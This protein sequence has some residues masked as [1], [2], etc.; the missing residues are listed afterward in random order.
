[1]DLNQG[2]PSSHH[3]CLEKDQ[4]SSAQSQYNGAPMSSFPAYNSS[5]DADLY[6]IPSYASSNANQFYPILGQ[7]SSGSAGLSTQT[8]ATIS[9]DHNQTL[10]PYGAQAMGQFTQNLPAIDVDL[11][12][13]EPS[14]M[15]FEDFS[16]NF[17]SNEG[18]SSIAGSPYNPSSPHALSQSINPAELSRQPS[19]NSSASPHPPSVRY[20]NADPL[21][22]VSSPAPFYTPQHSRH[23]SL[24]PSTAAY[25][26]NQPSTDWQGLLSEPH[27][28]THRSHTRAPSEVSDVSSVPHSPFLQHDAFDYDNSHS[29]LMSASDNPFADNTLGM[30]SFTLSDFQRSSYDVSPN[31]MSQ[32][33]SI[34]MT[35]SDSNFLLVAN[36]NTNHQH[37]HH[38]H[39][40]QQQAAVFPQR[41]DTYMN[42]GGPPQSLDNPN[43]LSQNVVA[44]DMGQAARMTP[45]SINVEFAP[46][47]RQ[48]SFGPKPEASGDTL[49]LPMARRGRSKSDPFGNTATRSVSESAIPSPTL[50]TNVSISSAS[51]LS[52]SRAG[53]LSTPGSRDTSPVS[54][55]RRQ[56]TSSIE[57]RNYIL[58]LADPQ[59]PG[60]NVSD[61]KRVQKHPASFQCSLCP[62]R[63][64]RAYNLRSHL[65]TH[66]DER[67][68]VCTVCGKAFA[69]Q[70]DRKRHEGLHSGEKKFVCNGTLKSA[71]TWG[72]GRRFA[73]ADALGRHFRSEAGRICI[74]PLLD[75]EA[76]ER[77]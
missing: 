53:N 19:P 45:P 74:K 35:T 13:L 14:I 65:R 4:S 77:E 23:T 47:S 2:I 6:S 7:D 60:G 32:Q 48:A 15:P 41:N 10:R 17:N 69:R 5:S 64:T 3:P 21:S 40:Q 62:K 18:H 34:D 22:P 24:D 1:M 63:F 25:M 57:N 66:T 11:P 43:S 72:C 27:F 42:N 20:S 75:E 28:R 37:H 58:D 55:S 71:K 8:G 59:R 30:E 54:R 26:S 68:F 29:P 51:S 44:G 12:K 39:Q 73:R 33:P 16:N 46:P 36:S 67:P 38:H 50:S 70:H 52:P 76:A 31:L 49:S 9:T 61:N 56:S